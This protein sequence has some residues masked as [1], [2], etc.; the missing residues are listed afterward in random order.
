VQ[1]AVNIQV[2]WTPL[3][4][5]EFYDW[6]QEAD[7]FASLHRSEGFGLPLAEAMCAGYPVVATGWSGNMDYMAQETSFPVKYRLVDVDDPQNVYGR[8]EGLWAEAECEH[9]AEIFLALRNDRML[10]AAVGAAARKSVIEKLSA[11]RF[12]APMISN[13]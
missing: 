12:V 2:R 6:W 4:R 13:G 9:A 11:S 8:T 10:A 1:N 3:G 5:R 7:A